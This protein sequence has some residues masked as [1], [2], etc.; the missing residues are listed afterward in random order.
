M[1]AHSFSIKRRQ[2]RL[3]S[4][5]FFVRRFLFLKPKTQRFCHPPPEVYQLYRLMGLQLWWPSPLLCFAH[6]LLRRHQLRVTSVP[7]GNVCLLP[8]VLP[9]GL[10]AT[11][12]TLLSL[13]VGSPWQ[14]GSG[15]WYYFAIEQAGPFFWVPYTSSLGL[16]W[17]ELTIQ[18]FL[19]NIRVSVGF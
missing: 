7:R 14:Q 15:V 17:Q 10:E 8:D 11:L 4:F 3:L 18:S 13:A 16:V 5:T 2:A 6:P 9:D 19:Q 12:P 1:A